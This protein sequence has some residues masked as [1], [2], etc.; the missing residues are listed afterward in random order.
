MSTDAPYRP[1]PSWLLLAAARA[2]E[3]LARLAPS[4]R[5]VVGEWDFVS[6]DGTVIFTTAELAAL[7]EWWPSIINMRRMVRAA[8]RG[9]L[10]GVPPSK[11][12]A[13]L[14]HWL[15]E[16]AE[17]IGPPKSKRRRRSFA[18]AR[19]WVSEP[20]PEA[21]EVWVQR[22]IR[23]EDDQAKRDEIYRRAREVFQRKLLRKPL[24]R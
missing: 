11:R 8:C 12:K 10:M 4:G 13:V 23:D 15:V 17:S 18:E 5:P 3:E 22:F 16:K 20:S 1:L 2:R 19:P 6:P 14:M 24:R 9:W 7:E 21:F